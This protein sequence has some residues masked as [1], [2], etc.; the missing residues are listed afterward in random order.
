MATWAETKD[1]LRSKLILAMDEPEWLGV[2]WRFPSPSG[3][4]EVVQRQRVELVQAFSE[5]HV[6]VWSD[7]IEEE[8]VPHRLALVFNATLA[9]GGIALNEN[10]YIIRTV[11]PLENL[12]FAYLERTM[13]HI[14]QEAVRLR[15]GAPTPK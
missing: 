4:E 13:R 6:L 1:Y 10:L 9:V 2:A 7:I 8:R 3:G 11:L 14:A 5:P 15:V 12:D